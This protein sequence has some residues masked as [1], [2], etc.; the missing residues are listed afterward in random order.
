MRRRPGQAEH[1]DDH[2]PAASSP[3]VNHASE[4]S[5]MDVENAMLPS[6]VGGPARCGCVSPGPPASR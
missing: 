3:P 4:V 1:R 5:A 6:L 2:A